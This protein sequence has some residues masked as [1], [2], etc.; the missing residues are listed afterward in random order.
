VPSGCL[1]FELALF[2]QGGHFHCYF[3]SLYDFAQQEITV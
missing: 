3:Y 2:Y 1:T